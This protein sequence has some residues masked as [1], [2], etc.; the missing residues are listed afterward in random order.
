MS[1]NKR[2]FPGYLTQDE[3]ALANI[4]YNEPAGAVK[5]SEQGNWLAPLGNGSNGFTTDASTARILPKLGQNIAL[6]NSDTAIHTVTISNS[7]TTTALAPGAT[8]AAGNVGI[9]VPPGTWFK[10][11]CFLNNWVVTDST[12]LFVYLI[13]DATSIVIQKQVNAST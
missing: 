8:N 5:T 10:T 9:P 1:I 7:N 11:C 13:N 2:N 3:G 4:E 12:L 6:Y